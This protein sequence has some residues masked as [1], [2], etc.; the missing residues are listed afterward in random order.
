[1]Q[2]HGP[3]QLAHG[4]IMAAAAHE[5]G[6][7]TGNYDERSDYVKSTNAA[8]RILSNL[9]ST[10]RDWLLVIAAYNCGTANVNRAITKAHSNNFWKI[11]YYLPEE[12]R[13]HVKKFIA[14]HYYFEGKRKHYNANR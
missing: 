12:T 3:V 8:A 7:H 14:T 2:F 13:N 1:M 5:S 10:Y 11:Q 4:K 6:L 9:Y